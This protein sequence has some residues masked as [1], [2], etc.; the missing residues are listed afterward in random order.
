MVTAPNYESIG[1]AD[2]NDNYL[3][4]FFVIGANQTPFLSM[5]GGIRGYKPAPGF[6]YPMEQ[7]TLLE[8]ATQAVYSEADSVAGAQT[9]T[10]YGK[11]QGLNTCQIMQR[12]IT[13]SYAKAAERLRI[14]GVTYSTPQEFMQ[15]ELDFQTEMAMR[16]MAIDFEFS[17]L[18]GTY[19]TRTDSSTATTTG[20]ICTAIEAAGTSAGFTAEDAGNSGESGAALTKAMVDS[21]VKKM[22]DA[23]APMTNMVIFAGS[24]QIQ[25]LSDLYGWSP[26]GGPGE[27]LGGIRVNR[28]MTQFFEADVVF[29]PQMRVDDILFCDIDKCQIRGAEVPGKG[30]IFVEPKGKT[31]A[32]DQ[33]QLIAHLGMDYGDTR[34][35]GLIYDLDY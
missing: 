2:I 1:Y 13:V 31:G 4:P 26:V 22:A 11:A 27:G 24:Y 21:C 5:M 9:P 32:S 15:E 34:F 28:L 3:G 35:H 30:A 6:S 25:A 12:N 19:L 20:G 10:T 29:A 17:C 33:Y 8:S 16:Q 7:Y 14:A 18:Q 23:G